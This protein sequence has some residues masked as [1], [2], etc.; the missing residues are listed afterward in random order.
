MKALM[1]MVA[2]T[3]TDFMLCEML[4]DIAFYNYARELRG[5]AA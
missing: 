1:T 4:H 5:L 2:G 3:A